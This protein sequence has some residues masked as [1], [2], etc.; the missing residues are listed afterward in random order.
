MEETLDLEETLDDLT[1]IDRARL[2]PIICELKK[3][4]TETEFGD[5]IVSVRKHQ[6][7]VI[8]KRPNIKVTLSNLYTLPQ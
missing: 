5:F 2:I 7:A 4:E 8:L 6:S 1:D 3:F